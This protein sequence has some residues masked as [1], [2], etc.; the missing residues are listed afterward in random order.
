MESTGLLGGNPLRG[1]AAAQP[2][3][4]TIGLEA[5]PRCDRRS[6][7][8]TGRTGSRRAAAGRVACRRLV[9]RVGTTTAFGH[10]TVRLSPYL[11]WESH[12]VAAAAGGFER[13]FDIIS[14]EASA[15]RTSWRSS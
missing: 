9:P 2:F 1:W 7:R 14:I 11:L 13:S 10:T 4:P 15:S 12:P 6:R 5:P 8:S 3:A